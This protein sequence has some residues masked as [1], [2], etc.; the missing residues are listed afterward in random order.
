M[1][2]VACHPF[3]S[4]ANPRAAVS[5]P[6]KW[7][8][9][10]WGGAGL[11]ALLEPGPAPQGPLTCCVFNPLLPAKGRPQKS[12]Q[13]PCANI[14]SVRE[15]PGAGR[16]PLEV[17]EEV[18]SVYLRL[19]T[20]GF[21]ALCRMAARPSPG[22]PCWAAAPQGH[23]WSSASS[24]RN[25]L[26]ATVPPSG[27]PALARTKKKKNRKKNLGSKICRRK[28]APRGQEGSCPSAKDRGGVGKAAEV[29]HPAASRPSGAGPREAPPPCLPRQQACPV[30]P[31]RGV[32]WEEQPVRMAT[33][34][35]NLGSCCFYHLA[36]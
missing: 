31:C 29:S 11:S 1:P 33:R 13:R 2:V 20:S 30:T 27:V 25:N 28:A 34:G 5:W 10:G 21:L 32:N 22:T 35:G 7:G 36:V 16:S 6:V 9:A 18:L 15:P 8:G 26:R 3:G 19:V 23:M 24:P 12:C 14:S 4:H 17:K